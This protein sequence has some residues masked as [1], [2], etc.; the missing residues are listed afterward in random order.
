[1]TADTMMGIEDSKAFDLEAAEVRLEQATEALAGAWAA[2]RHAGYEEM[3]APLVD[4]LTLVRFKKKEV[5]AEKKKYQP[6][7]GFDPEEWYLL[8]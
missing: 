2:M 4:C 1:M 3:A 6:K 7:K 8:N 5:A